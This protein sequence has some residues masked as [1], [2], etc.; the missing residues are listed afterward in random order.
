L[1]RQTTAGV[2]L[3]VRV[4]PRARRTEAV[5]VRD[6]ALLVR[7]TAPPVDGAANT[8]LVTFL[9][10]T[11]GVPSRAIQLLSGERGR[12]KRLLIAGATVA[13]VESALLR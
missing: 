8:A 9:A 4:I 1:I 2:E 10:S 6:G 5:G 3:A 11:L 7:L 13:Q 12:Q